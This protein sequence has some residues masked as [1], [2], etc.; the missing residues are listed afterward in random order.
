MRTDI[1]KRLEAYRKDL[2]DQTVI[3]RRRDDDD[4]SLHSATCTCGCSPVTQAQASERELRIRG[5]WS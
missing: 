4:Y 2:E 3:F 1:P 5:L